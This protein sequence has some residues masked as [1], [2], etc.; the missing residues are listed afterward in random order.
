MKQVVNVG[1]Y[2]P[3]VMADPYTALLRDTIADGPS[4]KPPYSEKE[5]AQTAEQQLQALEQLVLQQ[6]WAHQHM[7][8]I[9]KE[10]E[11]KH[12]KVDIV[13]IYICR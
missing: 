11:I 10:A 9:L 7:I 6:R 4:A 8:N 5:M 12:K 2:R 3:A 1:R 13:H